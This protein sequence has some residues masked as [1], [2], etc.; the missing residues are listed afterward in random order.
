MEKKHVSDSATQLAPP[1][2]RKPRLPGLGRFGSP[3]VGVIVQP[4]P[5]DERM[6]CSREGRGK[7]RERKRGQFELAGLKWGEDE[8]DGDIIT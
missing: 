6:G 3:A 7:E 2:M 8:D 4:E 5:L 1:L